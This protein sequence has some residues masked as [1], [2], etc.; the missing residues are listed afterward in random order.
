LDAGV[1]LN[2]YYSRD[3]QAYG[4]PDGLSF[5]HHPVGD[6]VVYSAESPDVACHELGHA[7]L[8][9]FRPQLFHTN[10]HE[11]AAFH[12]SF[13]DM[14]A[15]LTAL[16]IPTVRQAVL[17][18]T[19]S[20]LYRTSRL[21]R[22]AEQLGWAIR[23]F[24]PDLVDPDCLRNAVNSFL[25]RPPLTLPAG[26]P[27]SSLSSEP[28]S[29]S[30]VFTGAFL[31]SLAGM[32]GVG[33]KEAEL[34]DAAGR[35]A[36]LLVAAVLNT[37]VVPDFFSHVAANM[38]AEDQ[39]RFAGKD[40]PVLQSA[41]VRHGILTAQGASAAAQP[42]T[43]AALR[44]PMLQVSPGGTMEWTT[45]GEIGIEAA[46]ETALPMM[47]ISGARFGL[48]EVTLRVHAPAETT[49]LGVTGLTFGLHAAQPTASSEAASSFVT[50]LFQRGRVDVRGVSEAT[51][52][53]PL[54]HKTHVVAREGGELVL[55]R[56]AFDCGFD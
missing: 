54:A 37:P 22:L 50:Y 20:S 25:Y 34:L 2:A 27:A 56:V 16:Q 9:S 32:A 19:Q 38:I 24:R 1:D 10:F 11:V 21:S 51:L 44:Q 29:F 23:Q 39:S 52:T 42:G 40:A 12:E 3:G 4:Y 48:G 18:E 43:T 7:V 55:L 17:E 28:H 26:G 45:P 6:Q 46:L 8:D 15:L 53:H 49:G 13:G 47:G 41:F 14:S 5:F 33:S 30:R 31:E 36:D 35:A